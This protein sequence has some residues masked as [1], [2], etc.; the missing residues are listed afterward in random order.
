M[1]EG[2]PPRVSVVELHGDEVPIILEAQQACGRRGQAQGGPWSGQQPGFRRCKGGRA[3]SAGWASR[4]T[5]SRRGT[6]SPTPA[7]RVLTP[8]DASLCPLTPE[9]LP[10]GAEENSERGTAQKDRAGR[11]RR[12]G[13]GPPVWVT[14]RSRL[15]LALCS[16]RGLEAGEATGTATSHQA[17]HTTA[18]ALEAPSTSGGRMQGAPLLAK[19]GVSRQQAGRSPPG[20]RL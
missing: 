6:G 5:Q 2:D 8:R 12:L 11:R 18:Q 15:V 9:S 1:R 14:R 3:P 19:P 7:R 13:T 4:A 17:T 16:V 10:K 20:E